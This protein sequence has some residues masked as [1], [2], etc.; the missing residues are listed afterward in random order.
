[1]INNI[2]YIYDNPIAFNTF[3]Y[4]ITYDLP[5]NCQIEVVNFY[6]QFLNYDMNIPLSTYINK[7]EYPILPLMMDSFIKNEF[8]YDSKTLRIFESMLLFKEE[9][10]DFIVRFI[11][12]EFKELLSI[13][14]GYFLIRNLIK[15]NKNLDIQKRIVQIL[16]TNTYNFVISMNGILICK[17]II[18]NFCIKKVEKSTKKFEFLN[19]NLKEKFLNENE[20]E[21]DDDNE[22]LVRNENSNYNNPALFFFY[23]IILDELLNNTCLDKQVEKLIKYAIKFGGDKFSLTFLKKINSFSD[24]CNDSRSSKLLIFL[25]QNE[26]G[27]SILISLINY[28]DCNQES[29]QI[30]I[31]NIKYCLQLQQDDLI[32]SNLNTSNEYLIKKKINF[33]NNH[34]LK[35]EIED[36]NKNKINQLIYERE[37]HKN[38]NFQIDNLVNSYYNNGNS[39]L[40]D[41]NSNFQSNHYHENSS[42][43]KNINQNNNM[44]NQ[45]YMD[46]NELYNIQNNNKILSQLSNANNIYTNS[47]L[48]SLN[49]ENGNFSGNSQNQ[50]YNLEELN[51]NNLTDYS[52]SQNQNIKL[53]RALQNQNDFLRSQ[54]KFQNNPQQVQYQPNEQSKYKLNPQS[55]TVNQFGNFDYSNIQEKMNNLSNDKFSN[56]SS[57]FF[58][59]N[60]NTFFNSFNDNQEMIVNQPVYNQNPPNSTFYKNNSNQQ[61]SNSQKSTSQNHIKSKKN[62]KK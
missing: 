58:S 17:C 33:W 52:E 32:Y 1:M 47:S 34:I 40:F 51:S 37:L 14:Q 10:I 5:D 18:K 11:L 35:L 2:K 22:D 38:I 16:A 45:Y 13:R 44:T 23:N 50:K 41:F 8:F 53:I 30:L 56:L 12:T 49:I 3:K 42:N 24:N 55:N 20:L 54:L 60:N 59:N 28:F 48:G 26:I 6:L 62:K 7:L 19:K 61:T 15:E 43:S 25:I 46:K 27:T 29:K 21:N 9:Y 36:N 4:L 57:Q 39:N 31:N